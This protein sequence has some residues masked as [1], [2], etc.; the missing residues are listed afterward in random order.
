VDGDGV[1]TAEEILAAVQDM[2][3]YCRGPLQDPAMVHLLARLS[4]HLAR[5]LPRA[6]QAF[7]QHAGGMAHLGL[8]A[9]LRCAGLTELHEA[10]WDQLCT[11]WLLPA[12]PYSC[13]LW[14]GIQSPRWTL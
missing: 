2:R 8:A 4:S 6:A 11:S 7:R 14:V 9:A 10:P 3:S 5:N 12:S 13:R 1:V